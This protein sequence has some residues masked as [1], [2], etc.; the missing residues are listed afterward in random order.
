ML[1]P[2]HAHCE[3]FM[4]FHPS[5]KDRVWVGLR[6]DYGL[7]WQNKL[8]IVHENGVIY[9]TMMAMYAPKLCD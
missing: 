9:D 5:I 7:D 1:R 8:D 2:T 3:Y 6:V 4:V